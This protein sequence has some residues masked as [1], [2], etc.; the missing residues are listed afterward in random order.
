MFCSSMFL[1]LNMA[2]ACLVCEDCA[3]LE[4]ACQAQV[5][6]ATAR[7]LDAEASFEGGKAML[8]VVGPCL[9]L[10][11]ARWNVLLPLL[12]DAYGSRVKLL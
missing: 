2:S 9:V 3:W 12:Q 8:D 5:C 4:Q 10:R 11:Q 6:A 1:H 7:R